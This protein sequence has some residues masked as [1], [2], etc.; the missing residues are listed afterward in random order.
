MSQWVVPL[1][2]ALIGAV[3]TLVAA[4]VAYVKDRKNERA[5]ILQDLDIADKLPDDSEARDLLRA[6][7]ENRALLLPLENY[8]RWLAR[9]EL[10]EGFVILAISMAAPVVTQATHISL[11]RFY[12]SLFCFL[13]VIALPWIFYRRRRADLIQQY[14]NEQDLNPDA[15]VSMNDLYLRS[16]RPIFLKLPSRLKRRKTDAE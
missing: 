2:V 11:Q 14:L 16:Y 7:A 10:G 6:Y 4:Y 3:A 15:V 9:R 1:G 13:G 8:F 12:I 5:M